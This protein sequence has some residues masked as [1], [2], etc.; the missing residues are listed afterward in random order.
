[1]SISNILQKLNSRD[2]RLIP[3][4]PKLNKKIKFIS[5]LIAFVFLGFLGH[6]ILAE[7]EF[8]ITTINKSAAIEKFKTKQSAMDQGNNQESWMNEALM[9]NAMSINTAIAGTIP[10][11][12]LNGTA[13]S[14]IPGGMIGFTNNAI[15]AL[16]NPPASGV[17]YIAQTVNNF[18]GKPAYAATGYEGLKG[19]QNIWKSFRN[20]VYILFSVVFIGIGIAIM[21]RIKISQNAVITIQSALPSLITSLILVT[22]SY[23]IAGLLIDLSYVFQGLVLAILFNSQHGMNS[24]LFSGVSGMGINFTFSKLMNVGF[25]GMSDLIYKATPIW[26]LSI[27]SGV[28]AG[29]IGGLFALAG[30]GPGGI[31]IGVAAFIII[32]V[33]LLLMIIINIVKFFFGLVKCY[34]SLILRIILAPLEIGMGAIPNSKM[35][36]SS[37]IWNVIANL[38]VFPIS[39]IFLTLINLIIDSIGVTGSYSLWSPPMLGARMFLCPIIGLTALALLPKLPTLIP[40]FVFSIK[41]SEFGKALGEGF[42]EI[43]GRGLVGVG[44]SGVRAGVSGSIEERVRTSKFGERIIGTRP[45]AGG[46]N[47]NGGN[48]NGGNNNGNPPP[49]P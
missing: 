6:Q 37:W 48:N 10:D 16:Y 27:V 25:F 47:N 26:G 42:K 2:T 43:P 41:P 17:Q 38:A 40:Q 32:F 3:Q 34:I 9:S 5:I 31:I 30:T 4:L 18:L 11:N 12:V 29:I 21:L 45:A 28:A 20:T 13:T 23:A 33:I 46:G 36:F 1:M 7:E 39:L 44:T 49:A 8:D 15:A 19:I 14:W 24:E 35:N 22:F